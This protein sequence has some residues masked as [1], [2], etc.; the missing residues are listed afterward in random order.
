M[1]HGQ[2]ARSLPGFHPDPFDRMLIAQA[3]LENCVLISN[4]GIFDRYGAVRL[5]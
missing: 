2:R 1:R 4:E 5:R 3:I